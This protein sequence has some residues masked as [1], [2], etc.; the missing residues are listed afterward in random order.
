MARICA[1][2][3]CENEL[4]PNRLRY[5]SDRCCHQVS[6]GRYNIRTGRSHGPKSQAALNIPTILEGAIDLPDIPSKPTPHD[7]FEGYQAV[8]PITIPKDKEGARSIYLSDLQIP[9]A[10]WPAMKLVEHFMKDWQPDRIFYVGDIADFYGISKFDKNPGRRFRLQDER[11]W[12]MDMLDRHERLVPAAERVWLDGNHEERIVRYLWEKAPELADLRNE[13]TGELALGIPALF[14]LNKREIQYTSYAGHVDYLGFLI[15]HG[16]LL[17]KH[18]SYT[19]KQMSERFR[20]S[21]LSAHSHRLG[22]YNWTGIGG[23]QA[24]YENGCLCRMDPD[25][26]H[27]PNWQQG[28]HIGVVVDQKVHIAP[29]IIFNESMYLE[30]KVYR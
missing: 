16:N 14:G 5:C 26:T 10:D 11:Q 12:T 4:P 23:P 7:L 13:D 6:C 3:D 2:P 9:F 25:Y 20:S 8:K 15:T 18:S 19:A 24:W 29:A 21:G 17:S 28:F 1:N 22:M 27:N 30:G